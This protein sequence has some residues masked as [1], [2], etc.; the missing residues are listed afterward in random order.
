M[1]DHFTAVGALTEG[2][3]AEGKVVLAVHC[4][5]GSAFTME[6]V[7]PALEVDDEAIIGGFGILAPKRSPKEIPLAPGDLTALNRHIEAAQA[8]ISRS[9]PKA[10]GIVVALLGPAWVAFW[11]GMRM[12]R[13][14]LK[15][16]VDFREYDSA[17]SR[18]VLSA[19]VAA[20]GDAVAVGSAEAAVLGGG[21]G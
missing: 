7:K 10:S 12:N 16:R 19:V 14:A 1:E 6:M 20:A 17:A 8:W 15:G 5:K 21:A 13:R 11:L 9:T 3:A 4:F 18:Y 2:S